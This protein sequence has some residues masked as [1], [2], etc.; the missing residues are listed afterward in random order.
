MPNVY[1]EVSEKDDEAKGVLVNFAKSAQW[2]QDLQLWSIDSKE[3]SLFP[4]LKGQNQYDL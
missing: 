4:E 2:I 3:L 1:I